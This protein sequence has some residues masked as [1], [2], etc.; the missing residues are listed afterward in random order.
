[1]SVWIITK[2]KGCY[3][4][5]NIEHKHVCIRGHEISIS[6]QIVDVTHTS[7]FKFTL[8][9]YGLIETPLFFFLFHYIANM[10]EPVTKKIKLS[11]EP[12][13]DNSVVDIT[14]TGQEIFKT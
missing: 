12:S 3:I 7:V 4:I 6:E 9:V 13:I 14:N 1:M 2:K 8:R 5:V 11:L 10:S